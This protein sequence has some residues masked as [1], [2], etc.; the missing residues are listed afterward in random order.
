[1]RKG[2]DGIRVI[3][4]IIARYDSQ[5]VELMTQSSFPDHELCSISPIET[6]DTIS[7]GNAIL[8]LRYKCL[9]ISILEEPSL[10]HDVFC[11]EF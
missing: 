4:N 8:H 10:L 11:D 5:C 9:V 6:I 1:M 7:S 2:V 3:V